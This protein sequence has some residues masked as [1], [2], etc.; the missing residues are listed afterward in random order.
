M[1]NT[2]VRQGKHAV[3][4]RRGQRD[5]RWVDPHVT[6]AVRLHQRTGT[7]RVGFMVQNTRGVRIQDLVGLHLFKGRQQHVGFFPRL[8]LGGAHGDRFGL[9]LR[10]TAV[11]ARQIVA[12]RVRDRLNAARLVQTG[13]I[14]PGPARQRT[15]AHHRGVADVVDLTD[16]LA[17]S[18]AVRHF[19][20]RTLAVAV[21]QHVSFGVHQ[22]RTAYGIRPVIVVSDTTQA[23]FNAAQYNRHIF[24]SFF[25]ALA[26]NQRG[27]IRTL[28]THVAGG[29][30]I[31]VA[32]FA[33][34][35][36]AVDHRV[37][38]A[39]GDAEKQV[40]FAQPH[41]IFFI[42]P[43]RLRNDAD[44]EALRFQHAADD[45]HTKTRVVDIG[46]TTDNDHIAAIPAQLIHLF[47]RHR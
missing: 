32:Q 17:R 33:V 36:I 37:H 11:G 45:R 39:G 41:E 3:H 28:A 21:N 46:V 6:V 18:Q 35:G 13:R 29:I 26:V 38:V 42:A 9:R 2:L 40:R 43:V 16:F 14:H 24:I 1:R 25:T 27:A 22:H 47:A 44:A 30:G 8:G 20:Q 23:G 15:L 4:F 10:F 31:I 7:A 34:S 19:H 5:R 12:V